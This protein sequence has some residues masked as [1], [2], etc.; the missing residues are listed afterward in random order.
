MLKNSFRLL[1]SFFAIAILSLW[2]I[3]SF[4]VGPQKIEHYCE[5]WRVLGCHL[6][7]ENQF[8]IEEIFDVL[9]KQGIEIPIEFALKIDFIVLTENKITAHIPGFGPASDILLDSLRREVPRV[10]QEFNLGEIEYKIIESDSY[11]EVSSSFAWVFRFINPDTWYALDRDNFHTC[12]TDARGVPSIHGPFLNEYRQILTTIEEKTFVRKN[13]N[14]QESVDKLV[15]LELRRVFSIRES[16][17]SVDK[18][19][20]TAEDVERWVFGYQKDMLTPLA[21]SQASFDRIA[22]PSLKIRVP[23]DFVSSEASALA[24]FSKI[25]PFLTADGFCSSIWEHRLAFLESWILL[26]RDF[27]NFEKQSGYRVRES[28][29]EQLE[30]KTEISFEAAFPTTIPIAPWVAE[31]LHGNHFRHWHS[32]W[33]FDSKSC[34]V[35]LPEGFPNELL[36]EVRNVVAFLVN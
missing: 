33:D 10:F 28:P 9:S 34:W 27:P 11:D 17:N 1:I 20:V 6:P 21:L 4:L 22:H 5:D 36:N 14:S 8:P 25:E 31:N 26:A 30:E 24:S 19:L 13:L 7:H 12:L 3:N 16:Q 23:I 2:T 32:A 35:L 15:A 29:V 18:N